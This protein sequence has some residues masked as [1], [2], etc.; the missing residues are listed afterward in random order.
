[1]IHNRLAILSTTKCSQR[2]MHTCLPLMNKDLVTIGGH[3]EQP[4]M[5]VEA[6]S[7]REEK[8][9]YREDEIE[10]DSRRIFCRITGLYDAS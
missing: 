4:H 9:M 5:R 7:V 3:D 1:M 2:F 8:R 10:L 6:Q